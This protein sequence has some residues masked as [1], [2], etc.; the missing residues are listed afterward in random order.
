MGTHTEDQ[1]VHN[2]VGDGPAFVKP[3]MVNESDG[4]SLESGP[5]FDQN[6]TKKLLRKLDWHLVPFLAL[7]YLYV[8]QIAI[9]IFVGCSNTDADSLSWIARTSEMPALVSI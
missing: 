4:T 5:G 1:K 7:L 3:E 8:P 6:M 2:D 9:S